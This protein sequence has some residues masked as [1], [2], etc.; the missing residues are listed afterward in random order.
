MQGDAA[1]GLE[2]GKVRLVPYQAAWPQLFAAEAERVRRLAGPALLRIE[3]VGSTAVPGVDSKPIIDLMASVADVADA[4]ALIPALE[5]GGYEYRPE[6]SWAERVFLA[7]GP[8]S[9]RTHHL[10]LTL[11]HSAFW[12]DHLLFRDYLRA[13]AAEAAAYC[14]LKRDLARS[15]AE[16]RRA[17]TA[18]KEAFVARVLSAARQASRDTPG[19]PKPSTSQ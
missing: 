11:E 5:S 6:D 7:N 2:R 10:S 15:F 19:H 13:H 16:D 17:Y 1:L 3:H 9:A 18:A 14:A 4:L 12:A 8:R